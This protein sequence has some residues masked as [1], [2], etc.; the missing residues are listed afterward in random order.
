MEEAMRLFGTAVLGRDFYHGMSEVRQEQVR[1]NLIK[2]EFLGSGF[3]SL[4][5]SR[6]RE[7]EVPTLLLNGQSSPSIFHRLT[8]RLEELLP[9]S[10]RKKI[11]GA[12]HMMHEE[13]APAFNTAVLEFLAKS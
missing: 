7:L 6:V 1:V 8:D 2:A 9:H 5:A 11:P 13:N 3:P 10:E 4:A 12:S